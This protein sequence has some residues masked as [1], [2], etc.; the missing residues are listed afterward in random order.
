MQKAMQAL[1]WLYGAVLRLYPRRHYQVYGAEMRQVFAMALEERAQYGAISVFGICLK[2]A[3]E[4]PFNLLRAHMEAFDTAIGRADLRSIRRVRWI[5]RSAGV[6]VSSFWLMLLSVILLGED[7]VGA[8]AIPAL[9]VMLVTII[10]FVLAWRWERAGA[11]ALIVGS[12]A[13]GAAFYYSSTSDGMAPSFYLIS[14]TTLPIIPTLIVGLLL[15]ICARR[16]AA[17]AR[18]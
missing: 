18:K 9:V 14:L 16:S 7:R 3:I 10:S 4:L 2:E 15:H 13:L 5:A 6:L 1:V 17:L 8:R 12:L 11:I